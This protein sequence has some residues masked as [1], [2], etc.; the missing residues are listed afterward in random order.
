[1]VAVA[2]FDINTLSVSIA[3]S[4]DGSYAKSEDTIE[5]QTIF[6]AEGLLDEELDYG[7]PIEVFYCKNIK[8]KMESMFLDIE[9]MNFM[10]GTKCTSTNR[11]F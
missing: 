10:V 11:E 3:E 7:E 9:A 1:M 6:L 2:D 8:T 4:E 5:D